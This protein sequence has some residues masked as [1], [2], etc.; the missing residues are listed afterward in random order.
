MGTQEV[1]YILM[2]GLLAGLAGY[3]SL[4]GL[5][6][7]VVKLHGHTRVGHFRRVLLALLGAL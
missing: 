1:L 5:A 7:A 6:V 3:A 4:A 2:D